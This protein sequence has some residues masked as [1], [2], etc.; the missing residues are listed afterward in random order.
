M[1]IG[2]VLLESADDVGQPMGGNAGKGADAQKAGLQPVQL[3]HFHLKLLVLLTHSPRI[4]QQ[5]HA[6]RGQPHAGSPALEQRHLPL[7][8]KVSDHPADTGL[9]VVQ[10]IRSFGKA[11]V[12][13]RA[14]KGHIFLN[15]QFQC[16][17]PPFH[18]K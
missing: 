17:R 15:V 18:L 12:F 5:L 2:I 7:F 11:A 13:H 9:R 1:D 10:H 3:V 8:L 16:C 6:V 4:G 14:E